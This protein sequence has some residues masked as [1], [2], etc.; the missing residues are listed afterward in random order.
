MHTP[1]SRSALRCGTLGGDVECHGERDIHWVF[2]APDSATTSSA[3]VTLRRCASAFG[4][5]H[6]VVKRSS[7]EAAHDN[8][9]RRGRGRQPS[10]EDC[11]ARFRECGA[12]HTGTR[13]TSTDIRSKPGRAPLGRGSTW[14]DA[15]ARRQ[16]PRRMALRLEGA[17]LQHGHRTGDAVAPSGAAEAGS[18][19]REP[20]PSQQDETRGGD[21]GDVVPERPQDPRAMR[22]E[23]RR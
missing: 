9:G 11:P 10:G 2:G 18:S 13:S 16:P 4:Q 15:D 8:V 17:I 23:A 21:R 19:K 6:G 22:S 5:T 14:P 3:L 20:P 1:R 12:W 7:C